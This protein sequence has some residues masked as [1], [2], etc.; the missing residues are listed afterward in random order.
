MV[1]LGILWMKMEKCDNQKRK[2]RTQEALCTTRS[3]WS[4]DGW[5]EEVADPK[6]ACSATRVRFSLANLPSVELWVRSCYLKP[7][8]REGISFVQKEVVV[9]SWAFYRGK[10]RAN[11]KLLPIKSLNSRKEHESEM[12][13]TWNFEGHDYHFRHYKPLDDWLPLLLR[14][15]R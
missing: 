6:R 15:R 10:S 1:S 13:S 3:V 8:R 7:N 14:S 9:K 11:L 4:R 5:L 2:Q 12:E